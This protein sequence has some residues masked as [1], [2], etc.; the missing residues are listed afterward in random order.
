MSPETKLKL[1]VSL[2]VLIKSS[3]YILMG[4][5]GAANALG[6]NEVGGLLLGV[7]AICGIA[8]AKQTTVAQ[9]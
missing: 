5:G 2:P 9:N 7:A 6:Y 8:D 4:V 1:I 3:A